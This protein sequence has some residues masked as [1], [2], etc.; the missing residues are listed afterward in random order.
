MTAIK[1]TTISKIILPTTII[2]MAVIQLTKK[3]LTTSPIMNLKLVKKKNLDPS[4]SSNK[5]IQKLKIK[6]KQQKNQLI[7]HQQLKILIV[8]TLVGKKV[9][10]QL[11]QHLKPIKKPQPTKAVAL[12]RLTI[13]KKIHLNQ[14]PPKKKKD[15]IRIESERI[16]K[17]I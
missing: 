15:C 17:K 7:S 16:T 14:L 10:K 5:P 8:I 9:E 13:P 4:L 6:R 11:L 12:L 3:L 2:L 1:V